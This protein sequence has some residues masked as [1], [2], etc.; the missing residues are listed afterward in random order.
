MLDR[1]QR[2]CM[3]LQVVC[4][5]QGVYGGYTRRQQGLTVD[6]GKASEHSTAHHLS[7]PQSFN[8]HS[9]GS[10]VSSCRPAL[11]PPATLTLPPGFMPRTA[12]EM[13]G[14]GLGPE[15]PANRPP[16]MSPAFLLYRLT[17]CPAVNSS[18]CS[19]QTS[20]R[21]AGRQAGR[22]A[23]TGMAEERQDQGWLEPCACIQSSQATKD[24]PCHRLCT[25]GRVSSELQLLH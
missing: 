11:P 6:L 10:G 4:V 1:Q 16:A 7:D 22:Q 23:D 5:A 19:R 9:C 8:N 12:V 2:Q 13:A 20:D 14:G 18:G 25:N 15:P 17:C 24:W 3:G 21:W